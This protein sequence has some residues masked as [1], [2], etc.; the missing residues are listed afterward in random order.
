MLLEILNLHHIVRT[1][2]DFFNS[3]PNSQKTQIKVLND[4]IDWAKQ[5]KRIFLKQS[6]E[7]R[8]IGLYVL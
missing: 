4:N 5:E 6:L 2:L 1:L 7:T 8:L 3:I